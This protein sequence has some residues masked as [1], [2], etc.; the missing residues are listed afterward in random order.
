MRQILPLDILGIDLVIALPRFP[1]GISFS[2]ATSHK[3]FVIYPVSQEELDGKTSQGGISS[4]EHNI[5]TG[6]PPKHL[7]A[8]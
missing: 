5:L 1:H 7:A 8:N 2:A 3:Y 6:H 4:E